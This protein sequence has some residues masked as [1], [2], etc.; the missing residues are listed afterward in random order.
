MYIYV[1]AHFSDEPLCLPGHRWKATVLV[2][3]YASLL[4]LRLHAFLPL[5]RDGSSF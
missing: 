1:A 2:L 5:L 4:A 3:P